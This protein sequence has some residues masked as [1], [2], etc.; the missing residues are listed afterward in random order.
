VKKR[1]GAW[2][3]LAETNKYGGI[4]PSSWERAKVFAGACV[5]S[6]AGVEARGLNGVLIRYWGDSSKGLG[7]KKS[8]EGR[9][10]LE[11]R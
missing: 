9:T 6:G 3:I 1:D 10:L 5:V 4:K 8:T 7:G 2:S 11:R